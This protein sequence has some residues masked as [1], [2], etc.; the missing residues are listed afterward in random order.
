MK[1]IIGIVFTASFFSILNS[2]MVNV[3]LPTIM[4]EFGVDFQY[5][6][7]LYSGYMLPYAV[8]MPIFGRLG[9]IYGQKKIFLLGVFIFTI[10]S[11]LCSMAGGFWL[12]LSF[13]AVQALGA[14]AIMPNAMVLITSPFNKTMGA[15]IL[16]WW[17]MVSSTGSL[18]GPTLGG[19]LT[20]HI[21]W[22][23]IFYV[24]V[25]FAVA[26][27]VLGL[28]Y[29]PVIS[30]VEEKP[31][32]DK[33]GAVFLVISVI[34]LMLSITLMKESSLYYSQIILLFAVFIIFLGFFIWWEN[35]QKYPLVSIGLFRNIPFSATISTSF[36]QSM[37]MFGGLLLIPMYLQKVHDFSPTYSGI[38]ILPMS[39]AMMV[40]APLMGNIPTERKRQKSVFTGMIILVLGLGIFSTLKFESRYL[41]LACALLTTGIGLGI[42]GTPLSTSVVSLVSRE[43]VGVASGVFN[44]MR[45]LGGVVGS[46]IFG[47][48]LQNRIGYHG[49]NSDL[50]LPHIQ[51]LVMTES[52]HD[53]YILAMIIAS[54]GI[55]TALGMRYKAGQ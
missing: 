5:S 43:Q 22:H 3:A 29:I 30:T 55:L 34:S 39:L 49:E 37:A 35:K 10:G 23:S 1:L 6:T 40:M 38:L 54:F 14:A 26:V 9:D 18:I 21:G 16:G 51:Q 31:E 25:P 11:L 4:N 28:K 20:E 19:V 52:F 27:I 41:V 45:F 7:W 36:I 47:V 2:G 15:K 13:R 12:L 50:S 24:N 53:V 44:M 46:T 8:S 17:G 48:Y 33:L 42:S 32:F